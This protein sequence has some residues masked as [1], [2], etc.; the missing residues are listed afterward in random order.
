MDDS[1]AE[2]LFTFASPLSAGIAGFSELE[3]GAIKHKLLVL[4]FHFSGVQANNCPIPWN[5][6]SSLVKENICSPGLNSGLL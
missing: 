1:G 5:R 4:L 3:A 6:Y 2:C